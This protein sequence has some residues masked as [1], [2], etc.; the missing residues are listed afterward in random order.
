VL[1]QG[2]LSYQDIHAVPADFGAQWGKALQKFGK[3]GMAAGNTLENEAAALQQIVNE[4]NV[5]DAYA[6]RFDPAMRQKYSDFLKLRGKDAGAAFSDY[7]QQILDLARETGESLP[8][9]AQQGLFDQISRPRISADLDGMARHA[10]SQTVAW[11]NDTT[12]AMS[13]LYSRRIV[14]C[15]NDFD[16]VAGPA[17]LIQD[18]RL[19]NQA[20]SD[21]MGQD[22]AVADRNAAAAIDKGLS[23][24]VLTEAQINPDGAKLL[25]DRYSP[26]MSSDDVRQHVL[27]HLLPALRQANSAAVYKDVTAKFDLTN[28]DTDVDA[29]V[30][31]VMDPANYQDRLADPDQRSDVAK[32]VRGEWN[33]INQVRK[34]NQVAADNSFVDAL[35]RR[36]IAGLQLQTWKD[37][38]TGLP[39][40]DNILRAAID[41]DANPGPQPPPGDNDALTI[42]VDHISAKRMPDPGPI[43]E[44]WL[45]NLITDD[46]LK[47]LTFLYGAYHD[48]ALSRWYEDARAAF[49]A[50]FGTQPPQA[51]PPLA[52]SDTAPAAPD[53]QAGGPTALLPG[54]L[55]GLD[56]TVREQNLRNLQIRDTADRMLQDLDST[57]TEPPPRSQ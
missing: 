39:P 3:Q 21:L 9:P 7:R 57:Y 50:R 26:Y 52:G 13:D 24:A 44:A 15:R 37:P 20:Q 47:D 34:E 48:P 38:K 10:A 42:L 17:G 28:P 19:T 41:R 33:R 2:Q 11:Q 36:Q 43:N 35:A 12:G 32:A 40:S 14:D 5:N 6:N 8:N 25:Y 53:T 51:V 27:D 45:R 29:A 55:V 46:S 4:T 1:P 18:I 54:Y 23:D 49:D 16:K 56:Q 22:K 30:K 31:W